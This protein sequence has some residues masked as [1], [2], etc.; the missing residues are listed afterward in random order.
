MS[1]IGQVWSETCNSN[2]ICWVSFLFLVLNLISFLVSHVI[3]FSKFG[4]LGC[5][6]PS[7]G[8][9]LRNLISF[10]VLYMIRTVKL[11]GLA[12]ALMKL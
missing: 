11:K 8:W 9:Q 10:H 12:L 3:G 6:L 5:Y 4:L 1:E 7:A 2:G